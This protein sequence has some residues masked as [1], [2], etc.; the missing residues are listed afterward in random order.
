M[1]QI[2]CKITQKRRL[3]S[4]C[5]DFWIS[6][7]EMTRD[8]VAGQFLHIRCGEKVL[9]RPISICETDKEAAE[10]RIVFEV[11][12]EGTKWLSER[13][14]GEYL[15]VLGPLG[16][17]FDL[18]DTGRKALFIGG[19]IGV[20]PLLEAAKAFGRRADAVLGFRCADSTILTEDFKN[21]CSNVYIACEDGTIGS[22]GLV[23]DILNTLLNTAHYEVFYA[24][25]PQPMLH[26]VS[27][28][29]AKSNI[30]C[31]VSLEERMGCGVGACLV[32]A[33]KTKTG[34]KETYRHVCKDGPVFKSDEVEW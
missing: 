20:P 34:G 8:A 27:S 30:D 22:K 33:C 14:V 23:T 12:G 18:S 10:L 7:P 1:I 19:G 17:G 2:T 11:R 28:V 6:S 32:C 4:N 9:R 25:G 13:S 21:T 26:A 24:C 31:Y 3:H 5:F 15:D 29:A 16:N